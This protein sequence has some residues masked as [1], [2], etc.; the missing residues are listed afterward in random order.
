[1]DVRHFRFAVGDFE[2]VAISDGTVVCGPPEIPGSMLFANASQADLDL[3]IRES[4]GSLP[5]TR[6][7]E[8]ITCLLIDT[9]AQRILV[10]AGAGGSDPGTGRLIEALGSAGVAPSDVDTVI[11][12][13][14]HSDHVGGLIDADGSLVFPTARVLMSRMEW[15]FWMD[16]EAD[17]VLPV[18]ARASLVEFARQMF[19]KLQHC[20]ELVDGEGEPFEGVRYLRAPGHTPGHLAVELSSRGERLLFVGDL[21]LHPLHVVHPEW[22]SIWDADPVLVAQTRR[23]LFA[24]AVGEACLIHAFHFAFP[25]LGRL[26]ATTGGYAWARST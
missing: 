9:G 20:L 8:E 26:R 2:C 11:L 6:W 15:R 19:P 25:G 16:G 3:A 22:Y 21:I 4:A 12:S 17:R 7:T 24:K 13:H 1:M 10:D 23:A 18:E 14:G 5:L